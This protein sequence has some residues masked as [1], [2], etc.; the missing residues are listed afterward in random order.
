[1]AK[2]AYNNT[3]N[4][5]IGHMPFELNYGYYLQILYKDDVDFCFRSK[6]MNKLL[7]ELIELMIVCHKFS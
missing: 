2:F 4:A 7:A 1:M 5:S 3:K 6:S